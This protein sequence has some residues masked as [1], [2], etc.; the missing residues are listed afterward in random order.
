MDLHWF[1]ICNMLLLVQQSV[2]VIE[3]SSI[4]KKIPCTERRIVACQALEKKQPNQ[5]GPDGIQICRVSGVTVA[6]EIESE[7]PPSCLHMH[8]CPMCEMFNI[9]LLRIQEPYLDLRASFKNLQRT[10]R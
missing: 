5:S 3:L 10:S 6:F 4:H 7:L 8:E 9:I 1:K 2:L